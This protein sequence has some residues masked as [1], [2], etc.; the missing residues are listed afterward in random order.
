MNRWDFIIRQIASYRLLFESCP[1]LWI[2]RQSQ[3]LHLCLDGGERFTGVLTSRRYLFIHIQGQL[4]P[5]SVVPARPGLGSRFYLIES[6]EQALLH[7]S[8]PHTG[9]SEER[10]VGKECRSRWSPYH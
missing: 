8:S 2:A 6:R 5:D 4:C 3:L 9:R 7:S 1:L 10:R